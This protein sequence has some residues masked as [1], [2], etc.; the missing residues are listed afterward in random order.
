MSRPIR[1]S[2]P[3]VTDPLRPTL[4]FPAHAP[5]QCSMDPL[6]PSVP[7]LSRLQSLLDRTP[8]LFYQPL[9]RLIFKI[10][11]CPKII[12]VSMYNV[13]LLSSFLRPPLPSAPS[14]TSWT[15][16]VHPAFFCFPMV[17]PQISRP[18]FCHD[19]YLIST[20]GYFV[21]STRLPV[22]EPV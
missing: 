10:N 20:S 3:R 22:L 8:R 21:L 13:S 16:C 15:F 7:L 2:S 9:L 12:R 17:L 14:H 5:P 1:A 6:R 18:L 19:C 11:V 4:C